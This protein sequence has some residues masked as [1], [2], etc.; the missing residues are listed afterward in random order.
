MRKLMLTLYDPTN[1]KRFCVVSGEPQDV[2]DWFL[3]VAHGEMDPFH[4][5]DMLGLSG[6]DDS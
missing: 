6:E 1:G 4:L 3:L 2:A 5:R